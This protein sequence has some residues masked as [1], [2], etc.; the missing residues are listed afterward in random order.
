M[1]QV[2]AGLRHEPGL[3][4]GAGEDE[5]HR[6]RVGQGRGAGR[7]DVLHLKVEPFRAHRLR[8][9]PLEPL[10]HHGRGDIGEIPGHG[11]LVE[12]P[13]VVDAHDFVLAGLRVHVL[14]EW[15]IAAIK[16]S[17]TGRYVPELD[18]E[19]VPHL[20][21]PQGSK[22]V[23]DDADP[24][25]LGV[26]LA[27]QPAA[28]REVQRRVRLLD[29]GQGAHVPEGNDVQRA[30]FLPGLMDEVRRVGQRRGGPVRLAVHGVVPVILVVRYGQCVGPIG[31][32]FPP[33]SGAGRTV[34]DILPQHQ[35]ALPRF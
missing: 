17:K 13:V 15:I 26:I 8:A 24:A 4:V 18:E 28:R 20:Q 22:V 32:P 3:L 2:R 33:A 7:D 16:I 31:P 23:V 34:W 9:R 27:V 35:I 14:G 29:H 10:R 11:A 19:G 5:A 12:L 1:L 30:L 6:A 21:P 25:A